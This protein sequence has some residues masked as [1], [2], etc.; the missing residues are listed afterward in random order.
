MNKVIADMIHQANHLLEFKVRLDGL[1][2]SGH[3]DKKELAIL[4]EYID[5]EVARSLRDIIHIEQL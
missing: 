2:N 1:K 4:H 5:Q 3:I